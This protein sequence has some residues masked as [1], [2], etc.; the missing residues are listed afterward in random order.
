MSR[1]LLCLALL[2]CTAAI[3]EPEPTDP[4]DVDP[5]TEP[6]PFVLEDAVDMDRMLTHLEAIQAIADENSGNRV[7]LS[8]GYLDSVDY[9]TDVLEEAGL[10][11]E[12]RDYAIVRYQQGEASV[13][14]VS[15]DGEAESVSASVFQYSGSGEIEAEVTAV[16]V[17]LPPGASENSSTSGCEAA[18]FAGFPAGN[19]A[20]IQ[21]GSCRFADK[22]NN[23]IA[24][25][26]SAVAIFNEGQPGRT[27]VAEGVLGASA[28]AAV[29][30][31]GLSFE[32]GRDLAQTDGARLRIAVQTALTEDFDQNILVTLPGRDPSR[33]LIIGAHL[34][35]VAAGPG[36]NDNASG[37]AFLLE[38]AEQAQTA[39]WQPETDVTL[40]WWGA[41]EQGLV[42][43]SRFFLDEAGEPNMANLEGIEAY[44]N[45]DMMASRNGGRF[46]YDGDSST[47]DQD[48]SN[49][50]SVYLEERFLAYFDERELDTRAVGIV[51]RADSYWAVILGIPWGGLFSGAEENKS[52]REVSL[53]GGL[54][55]EP[56]D[57]CYHLDCD[58]LDG[59]NMELYTELSRAGA[60]LIQE[61]AESETRVPGAVGMAPDANA[62]WV[63]GEILDLPRPYGCHDDAIFDR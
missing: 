58:T 57:A 61:L 40:A 19:I 3:T 20:L 17:Q 25:G 4:T 11:P 10:S 18:D 34:D 16:D 7:S 21:R 35:S 28:L 55:G 52:P 60:F 41:E 2:G 39:G 54:G 30:V 8:S 56:Y 13:Q 48:L 36:I 33:N 27:E 63:P 51:D 26:A 22:A 24:A 15:A 50:G 42:G 29:P 23:A 62:P 53:F 45:F 12:V 31:V 5:D 14:R 37:T 47:M 49:P 44:L 38:I 9:V 32:D 59:V 1:A 6:A 43:S 46:V